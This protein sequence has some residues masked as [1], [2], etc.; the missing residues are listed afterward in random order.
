MKRLVIFDLDGTLV[1]TIEDLG[2][3]ANHVLSQM[4]FPL[5][6]TEEYKK[7]VGNG[8]NKLLLRSLPED[9]QDK[10]SYLEKMRALFIPYYDAHNTDLSRPYEG[11]QDLLWE[12]QSKGYMLSVASNK[13]ISAT[14]KVVRTYFPGIRFTEV[15]GQREGIP[16]KPDTRIVKDI[17]SSTHARPEETLY[18]GDTMVDAQTAMNSGIDFCAVSWGFR[19]EAELMTAHPLFIVHHPREILEHLERL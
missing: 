14:R 13:Y 11:I 7:K 9:I 12:L 15:L 17:L 1:N 8:I 5:H 19:P 3:A 2:G 10:E 4:G 6:T 18:V 16:T